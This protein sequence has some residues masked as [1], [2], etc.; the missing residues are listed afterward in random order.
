MRLACSQCGADV[1]IGP[2]DRFVACSHCASSLLVLDGRTFQPVRVEPLLSPAHARNLAGDIDGEPAL[3]YV[4]YWVDGPS[5]ALACPALEVETGVPTL[6]ARPGGQL[7]FHNDPAAADAAADYLD[8][9]AIP[10]AE[11]PAPGLCY[12]PYYRFESAAA[13][14]GTE[15]VWIDGLD[16]GRFPP[17]EEPALSRTAT[18]ELAWCG[19]AVAGPLLAGVAGLPGWAILVA[20]LLPAGICLL[21]RR[22]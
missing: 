2:A 17:P 9:E 22:R 20:G 19:A 11:S 8:P 15:P 21:A 4:P 7:G 14:G 10:G 6:R 18:K 3:V 13:G 1:E 16:G 5:L 12:V